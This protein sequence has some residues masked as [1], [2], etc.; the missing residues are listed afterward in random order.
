M[1]TL[2]YITSVVPH[3][4]SGRNNKYTVRLT[5]DQFPDRFTKCSYGS[6]SLE[7]IVTFNI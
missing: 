5:Q 4:K 2:F 7:E 6:L 3:H 1:F